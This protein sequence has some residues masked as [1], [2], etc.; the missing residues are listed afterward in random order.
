MSNWDRTE[1]L[2]PRRPAGVDR[3]RFLAGLGVVAGA[4]TLAPFAHFT[5]ERRAEGV[6]AGRPALGTWMRV[7]ARHEDRTLASRA[8][9]AAFAAVRR[10]DA[11]M[12]V[13]RSDSQLRRVNAAAGRAAIPVDADVRA[14]VA[15]ACTMARESGGVYDA[16]V[17][18]LML[19]Y[20]F[21]GRT[22]TAPPSAREVDAAL[23]VVGSDGV[24]VDGAAGTVALARTGAGL[25]LGSIGKGWAV[26][27]AV[28]ALRAA[29]VRSGMVDIGGNVYGLGV[30]EDG[31]E[32]WSVGVFH[33]VSHALDR[34]FVLRDAAV[35]T[36][37]NSEQTRTLGNLTLGHLFDA[38]RGTPASGHLCVT[39]QARTGMEA[40]V[41]ST[42]A[43]LL[44]P[45]RFRA[46]DVLLT[47]FIG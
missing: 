28:A 42:A 47:H 34:V 16:T 24:R 3:R 25:D 5:R 31:A 33:P 4:A 36:S 9:E 15:R 7:V 13:H 41:C 11:Q 35:A 30:P 45:D 8:I 20:G 19:A 2:A 6:E 18:P 39:V 21:Y 10:V 37:G 23:A 38:R 14:V 26:D 12:S 29:G 1:D 17:L 46:G 43:F 40:D 27:A 44:G 32:G 22:R